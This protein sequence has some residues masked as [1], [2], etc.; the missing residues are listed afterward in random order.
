NPYVSKEAMS[1]LI[2]ELPNGKAPGPNGILNEI[3]K[4]VLP[5][6]AQE[7]AQAVHYRIILICLKE[8]ITIALCKE[9]KK[10]YSLLESYQP[11]ALE[12]TLAK[13]IKKRVADMIAAAA[14]RHKL[15]P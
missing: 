7:L 8:S 15:L 3:L 6:I 10:D 14:K 12:N 5:L 9:G 11:I 4:I 1:N 13:I 2:T